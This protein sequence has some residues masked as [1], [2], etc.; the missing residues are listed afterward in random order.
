MESKSILPDVFDK[1]FLSFIAIIALTIIVYYTF[2]EYS[3]TH[4]R[5]T[6]PPPPPKTHLEPIQ[7]KTKEELAIEEE[8]KNAFQPS[9]SKCSIFAP[10]HCLYEA[11]VRDES[12]NNQE[13]FQEGFGLD[14]FMGILDGLFKLAI[15]AIWMITTIPEHMI[16]FGEGFI[17]LGVGVI[18]LFENIIHEVMTT[19]EDFGKFMIDVARCGFTWA[20]NLRTCILWYILETIIYTLIAVFIWIPI[21]IVRLLTFGKVDLNHIYLMIMGVSDRNRNYRMRD[22]DGKIVKKDGLM[23]KL[24]Q[25]LHKLSGLHF[26]HF[27]DNVIKNCYACEILEDIF[28]L[29]YDFTFGIL[30]MFM[31]PMKDIFDA[32]KHFW[33][34]FYLDMFFG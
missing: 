11:F 27:P 33:H 25:M 23:E 21:Y 32:G 18:H 13:G 34:A 19:L 16:A 5:E 10:E 12:E 17:Q 29:A 4:L 9:V 20:K 8:E 1:T 22:I 28:N 24:D 14:D 30:N 2:V 31:G 6:I 3:V 7:P 26:M 15:N